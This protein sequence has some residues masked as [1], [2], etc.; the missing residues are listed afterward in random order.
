MS[1]TQD[2]DDDVNPFQPG[3]LSHG[4]WVA[5]RA[6]RPIA[7]RPKKMPSSKPRKKVVAV[8]LTGLGKSK[9]QKGSCRRAILD[10]IEATAGN[11]PVT[12]VA[13]EEHFEEYVSGHVQKLIEK[14]HLESV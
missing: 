13:L 2:L 10:W 5:T 7:P 12:I 1:N 11:E 3:T 6:M 4:L 8:R 14:E 9:L